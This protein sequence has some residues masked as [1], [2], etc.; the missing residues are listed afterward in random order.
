[1][2]EQ[3]FNDKFRT[4]LQEHKYSMWKSHLEKAQFDLLFQ[5]DTI[6]LE[7]IKGRVILCS[8]NNFFTNINKNLK[9]LQRN[10][11]Q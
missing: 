2:K 10:S 8:L 6:K 9:D 11:S 5:N 7:I 1:M 4:S 3:I